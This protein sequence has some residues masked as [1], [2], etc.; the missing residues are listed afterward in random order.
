MKSGGA[1]EAL[2]VLVAACVGLVHA[3]QTGAIGGVPVFNYDY[4]PDDVNAAS[5]QGVGADREH[6]HQW[7]LVT[8]PGKTDAQVHSICE[9]MEKKGKKCNS[10]GHPDEGGIGFA[11]I[12]ATYAELEEIAKNH[13]DDLDFLEPALPVYA[14]GASNY[15]EPDSPYSTRFRGFWGL[16][17]LD[18]ESA[19]LDGTFVP[20]ATGKGVHVYVF[21][22]GISAGH[23][24]FEGRAVAWLDV[25]PDNY[26]PC[27]ESK[28]QQDQQ[29]AYFCGQDGNGHGT[30][31]A[32]TIGGKQS[33]VAKKANLYGV[34]V[35]GPKGGSTAAILFAM[36]YALK[37]GKKPAVFS[38]SLGGPKG[39]ES[40]SWKAGVASAVNSGVSVVVAAGNSNDDACKYSPAFIPDAITVASSDDKD[41]RS[42]FS[43]YGSCIDIFAPGSNILS[44]KPGL[45]D[46]QTM[47][48][49][50]M[51]C[52]HV[53]GAIA[54]LLEK[55]PGM[56]PK[57][58]LQK[59][60]DTAL[61]DKIKDV[62]GSP[63]LLLHTG[64]SPGDGAGGGGGNSEEEK[65]HRRRR[66]S[67]KS[68]SSR[69]RRRRRSGSSSRRR[70]KR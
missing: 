14:I 20:P 69:R 33:G 70:R 38:M 61:K 34:K 1:R 12:N 11:S 55:N 3:G 50:S 45:R 28:C 10:E 53:T 68:R 7:I 49:T 66:R 4:V 2:L 26:I 17:R 18:D 54:L 35:L 48:G 30:H 41:Q 37:N 56:S 29:C 65:K 27:T 13:K 8:K 9:E 59:L 31:C 64:K 21:D 47:S 58:A 22:T 36:D 57:D 62:K 52:P 16:D 60:K 51:A 42:G 25:A 24:D 23:E 43:C 67:R 40:A 15:S 44:A 6:E 46:Y 19:E 5:S 32:G 39:R 63:N